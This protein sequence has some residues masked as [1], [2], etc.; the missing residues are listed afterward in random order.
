MS[1]RRAFVRAMAAGLLAA[2]FSVAGVPAE[3]VRRVGWLHLGQP[4]NLHQF[5]DKM[6]DLGWIEGRNL[7]ID[8]RFADNEVDRLPAL[9][10]ELVKLKVDVIVTQSTPAAVAAKAATSVIPIVMAGS[11]NPEGNGL[12]GSLARP[13]G[14]VT[15]VTHNPGRGFGLKLVQ[16]IKEAAPR[17]SRLAVV[18]RSGAGGFDPSETSEPSETAALGVAVIRAIANTQA[19]LP[20]ALAAALRHGADGLYI[21]STPV[22]EAQK[23]WL[24]EF[25]LTHRLPAIGGSKDLVSAGIL[26][27]YWADWGELRR[28]A[29]VYVDKILKGAN[30]GELPVERPST[31]ELAINLS[32]ARSLRLTIPHALMLRADELFE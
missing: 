32:T 13:G 18:D 31:F 29:A 26:M 30:P 9:A 25:A 20:T 24:A 16:M 11:S 5:R 3:A 4:W 28:Q 10:A 22:N 6:K 17:V 19:E 27:S 1:D 2:P 15:G 7:V 14:N 12:V 23:K 21:P 8:P